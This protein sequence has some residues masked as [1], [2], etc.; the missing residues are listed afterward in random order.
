MDADVAPLLHTYDAA[1]A[2]AALR[3]A[4]APWH[5]EKVPDITGTGL[6]LIVTACDVEPVQPF[7]LVT[8]TV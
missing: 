3:V 2:G 4:E 5:A 1:P 8:V 6:V 7:A